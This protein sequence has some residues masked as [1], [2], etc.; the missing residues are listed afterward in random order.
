MQGN[1]GDERSSL[2]IHSLRNMSSVNEKAD[3]ESCVQNDARLTSS[4]DRDAAVA[5]GIQLPAG[6]IPHSSSE[7]AACW[8]SLPWAQ[9]NRKVQH[10]GA[11]M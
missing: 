5:N 4:S 10:S 8:Q 9:G 7:T 11:C 6:N 2:V 3:M 1:S